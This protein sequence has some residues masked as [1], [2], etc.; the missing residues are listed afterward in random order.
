MS[1]P[2]EWGW[3]CG[4]SRFPD[5]GR[6]Y[7]CSGGWSWISSLWSSVKCPVMSYGVLAWL[8]IAH[9]L[10][11]SVVFVFCW[12][13][14]MVCLALE[15]IGSLVELGFRVGIETFGSALVYW[16]SLEF[17]VFWFSKV[18]EL[19]LLS[20]GFGPSPK[21]ASRFL[22]P[23]STEDKTHRLMVKQFSTARNTQIDSQS[24]IDK[25]S[26]TKV[27]EM[28]KRRKA[29]F[30]SGESSQTNNLIHGWKWKWKIK[31]LK[32]QNW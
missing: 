26:R 3:S 15:L 31:F 16:C 1:A 24:Y 21:V 23:Y 5:W 7:S 11:F 13:I 9:L 4:L 32:V 6:L 12:R 30:K 20:L 10:M 28:T 17:S 25:R 2:C 18:L 19:S 22:H 27:I 14:S 8:C 29:A